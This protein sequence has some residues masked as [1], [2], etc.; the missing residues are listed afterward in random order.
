MLLITISLLLFKENENELWKIM[1]ISNKNGMYFIYF[2]V[3]QAIR[4]K[5]S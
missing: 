3:I 5:L 2:N 4:I 1:V